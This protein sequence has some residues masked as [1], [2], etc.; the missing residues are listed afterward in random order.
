MGVISDKTL[1]K[2]RILVVDDHPLVREAL[3]G[4]I[5]RQG[6]FVCCGEAASA[7]EALKA[8]TALKPDLVLLDLWLGKGDG[9]DLI[10]NMLA[11]HPALRI[12]ILSQCDELVYAERA[13]RVGAHG[14]VMKEQASTEVLSAMKKVLAGELYVSPKMAALAVHKLADNKSRNGQGRVEDLTD[15]ELQVFQLLGAGMSTRKIASWLNLSFKTIETH[16]ENIKH[17]LG[18]RDATELTHRAANWRHGLRQPASP[19]G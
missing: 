14:Y 17:K 8:V 3:T 10:K 1:N 4:V 16:R 11:E 5:R 15:R 6:E 7:S 12:L 19:E 13:L 9:L 2:T 18:L